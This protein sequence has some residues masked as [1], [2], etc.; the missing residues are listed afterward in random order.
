MIGFLLPLLS[1][2]WILWLVKLGA[3]DSNN[4]SRFDV[5]LSF[6]FLDL[7]PFIATRWIS[8]LED[9]SFSLLLIPTRKWKVLSASIYPHSQST[10][11]DTSAVSFTN[12]KQVLFQ[13]CSGI[14]KN[15]APELFKIFHFEII[16]DLCKSWKD[17]TDFPDTLYSDSCNVNI[18]HNSTVKKLT[19]VQ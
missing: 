5:P 19:S 4:F 8:A 6:F 18:T 10:C 7:L 13:W 11:T 15:S 12:F 9:C 1:R 2:K 16:L 17:R 14:R 3:I